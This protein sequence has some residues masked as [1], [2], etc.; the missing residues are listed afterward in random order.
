MEKQQASFIH[1]CVN[2]KTVDPNLLATICQQAEPLKI[3][4]LWSQ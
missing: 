1:S 2:N 3:C 4:E